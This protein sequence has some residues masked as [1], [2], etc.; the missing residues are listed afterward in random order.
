MLLTL[1]I[2]LVIALLANK[3]EENNRLTEAVNELWS[4]TTG[5]S[6]RTDAPAE[7]K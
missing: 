4:K 6:T 7:K 3:D 2:W 1:F 5:D